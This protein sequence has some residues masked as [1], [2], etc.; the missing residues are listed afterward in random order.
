V[1]ETLA[2]TLIGTVAESV[3]D[4]TG[5]SVGGIDVT[6]GICVAAGGGGVVVGRRV[7]VGVTT[8]AVDSSPEARRGER[9]LR[10][11]ALRPHEEA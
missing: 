9:L 2:W 1:A 8:V 3:A 4:G 11:D 6:R 10:P 5:V 7:A